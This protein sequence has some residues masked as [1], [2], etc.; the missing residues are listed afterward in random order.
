MCRVIKA[1]WQRMCRSSA[2]M[3]ATGTGSRVSARDAAMM[4]RRPAVNGSAQYRDE[5]VN[6]MLERAGRF[7]D[8]ATRAPPDANPDLPHVDSLLGGFDTASLQFAARVLVVRKI[9]SALTLQ[10]EEGQRLQGDALF[11]AG[12]E[13]VMSDDQPLP[14]VF[15][16]ALMNEVQ[17]YLKK[18]QRNE[19]DG[20]PM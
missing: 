2:E 8:Q 17:I 6:A 10:L 13:N 14:A 5:T 12:I 15:H 11:R 9:L 19:G 3:E 16:D 4:M 18:L 20:I 7:A 1:M